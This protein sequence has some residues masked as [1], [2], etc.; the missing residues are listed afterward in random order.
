VKANSWLSLYGAKR[1]AIDIAILAEA[2]RAIDDPQSAEDGR[3]APQATRTPKA[4][5]RPSTLD[6]NMR[7]A[8]AKAFGRPLA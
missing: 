2:E 3:L 5:V 4:P 8:I 1:R 7:L 6:R